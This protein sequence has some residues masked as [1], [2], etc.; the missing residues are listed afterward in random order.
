MEN[1]DLLKEKYERIKSILN[2]RDTRLILA[3]EA[4]SLGRGGISAVSKKSGV[5]RSTLTM[6][7]L[8]LAVK[9]S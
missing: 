2:E 4:L 1:H 5:S 3:S 9:K 7:S 6:A 8:N